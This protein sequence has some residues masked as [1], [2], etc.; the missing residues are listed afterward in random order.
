MSRRRIHVVFEHGADMRPFGSACINLI[1]PLTHPSLGDDLEITFGPDYEGQSVDLVIVDRLWRP[2]I[3]PALVAGLVE[4]VRH[5]GAHLLY[6]VDDNFLDLPAEARDW[7]PNEDQ[8]ASLQLLLR[9]A[10][11]VQVTTQ[12]LRRRFAD[13]NSKIY[14]IPV[15]LDERL[16]PARRHDGLAQLQVKA[17]LRPALRP[18]HNPSRAETVIGYMG[19]FT[20]DDDLLMVLPALRSVCERHLGR[21]QIQLVGVAWRQETVQALEGL[22]VCRITVPEAAG[23]YPSFLQWFTSHMDWD[24]GIA[25]LC[26]TPFNRCKSELK[27]LDYAALGVAGIFSGMPVYESSVRHMETGWVAENEPSA[28]IEALEKLISNTALRLRMGFHAS[29]YLYTNRVLAHCARARLQPIDSV[30]AE[31]GPHLEG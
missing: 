18:W 11:G 26:D 17:R 8:M 5:A 13:Y 25:P 2:D 30:L 3:T 1:Q 4:R 19:T 20:H 14:V 15:A 22:P 29:R 23:E 9:A 21:V 24:I 28:W 12:A 31:G 7:Q 16:L 6:A 27:F 10:D